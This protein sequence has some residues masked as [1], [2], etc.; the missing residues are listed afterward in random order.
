MYSSSLDFWYNKGRKEVG[1]VK[2]DGILKPYT[3]VDN[4]QT[5][6]PN[7]L[8]YESISVFNKENIKEFNWSDIDGK[9]LKISV[10]K[11]EFGMS[12]VGIDEINGNM[13]VLYTKVIEEG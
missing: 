7:Q 6:Y 4:E 1:E 8:L 3:I 2:L 5:S 11:G 12:V 10:Y 13:Y 9:I